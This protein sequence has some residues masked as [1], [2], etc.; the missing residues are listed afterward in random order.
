MTKS[1]SFF[2]Q[3]YQRYQPTVFRF[4]Y[5][6]SGNAEDAQD[7]CSETFL[8]MW[9]AS[10]SLNADTLKAYLLTIARNLYLQRA[11]KEKRHAEWEGDLVDPGPSTSDITQ[12]KRQLSL[13]LQAMQAL[14]EQDRSLLILKAYEGLTYRE[15]SKLLNL[16][17]PALKVRMHRAREKLATM[18]EQGAKS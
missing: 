17:V 16:S 5:W 6:L 10:T 3:V 2:H 11:R 8:R 13:T 15:I 18:T 9:T 14:P 4:A 7:I 1:D 12:S